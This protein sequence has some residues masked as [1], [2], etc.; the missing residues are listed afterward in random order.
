MEQQPTSGQAETRDS[1]IIIDDGMSL[2]ED[3]PDA[4]TQDTS[5]SAEGTQ[6]HSMTPDAAMSQGDDD[7]ILLM[8]G[9]RGETVDGAEI[10]DTS[11]TPLT[12]RR[13]FSTPDRGAR[14]YHSSRTR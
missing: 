1:Q 11:E 4:V 10:D 5:I 9:W 6:W 14:S 8:R 2:G 12:T 7:A 13:I 3:A